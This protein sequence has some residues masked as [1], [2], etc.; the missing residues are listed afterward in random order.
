MAY[1]DPTAADLKMRKPEFAAV[2]DA[3]ITYW[4]TDA[5]RFV[6]QSW[7]EGDYAPGLIAAAAHNMAKA[8]VAGIAGSDVAGFAAAG[9]TRF[10]SGTFDAQF[11][12]EAVKVAVAGGWESTTYGQ[13]YLALLRRNV[14]TFGVTASGVAPCGYGF[15]GFA[16]PLPPWVWG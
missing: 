9:V 12:D 14:S 10:K 3:V 11:S 2:D 8:P 5:H 16:G 15:N 7:A 4:L 6:D 13:E 1:I